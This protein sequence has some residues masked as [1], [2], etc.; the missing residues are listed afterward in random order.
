M[1]GLPFF[2]AIALLTL[3]LCLGG[4]T[5]GG[6]LLPWRA[7]VACAVLLALSALGGWFFSDLPSSVMAL[8]AAVA[9]LSSFAALLLKRL[10]HRSENRQPSARALGLT[11]VVL[12]AAAPVAIDSARSSLQSSPLPAPFRVAD[13]VYRPRQLLRSCEI[14]IWRHES[15][16]R[17]AAA[18][19]QALAA[20]LKQAGYPRQ[21]ATP[22][23][24]G[25]DPLSADDEWLRGLGCSL[26]PAEHVQAIVQALNEPGAYFATNGRE[27]IA[28]LPSRGW[29][30]HAR[31]S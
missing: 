7:F 19:W 20:Q 24:Q 25:S 26:A 11:L 5:V 30:V 15:I 27:G 13:P 12:Y 17:L 1:V 21:E 29:I 3:V 31:G 9:A 4:L 23:R 8:C 16:A 6:W 18:D 10:R 22:Y 2:A 14:S 28:V